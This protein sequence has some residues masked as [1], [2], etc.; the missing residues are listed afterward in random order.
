MDEL[1]L[2]RRLQVTG[3]LVFDTAWRIGTGK[4]G[5][6]MSDLGVLLDPAGRPVLPGS[7][8][9]GRLR[10][11]CEGLSHALKLSACFLNFE[12]SKVECTSDV[13]YYSD[14]LKEEHT[15]A[16]RSGPEAQLA[17]IKQHTCDVCKLFGSPV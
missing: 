13:K 11:T 1:K 2:R 14:R 12:A 7:S 9:K 10:G 4:E 8:L 17:W 15:R 5:T 3:R 16:V 6:T